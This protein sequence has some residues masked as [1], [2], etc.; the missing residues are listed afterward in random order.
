MM[1]PMRFR[2]EGESL[3][4]LRLNFRRA[5]LALSAFTQAS[6]QREPVTVAAAG[7]GV[8]GPGPV[9]V[10]VAN[11]L[12][13]PCSSNSLGFPRP[14]GRGRRVPRRGWPDSDISGCHPFQKLI[15]NVALSAK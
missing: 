9:R 11:Q 4:C 10:T 8:P 14:A 5:S 6:L 15:E 13:S 3:I 12:E 1:V 7:T 2:R